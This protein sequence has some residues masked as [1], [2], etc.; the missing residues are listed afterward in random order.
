[1]KLLNHIQNSMAQDT[2]ELRTF[3]QQDTSKNVTNTEKVCKESVP[4]WDRVS[5]SYKH[6]KKK[7]MGST[8]NA[9]ET[10]LQ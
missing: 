2:R 10:D 7:M 5:F 8:G 6:G 3:Q 9:K 4:C 1:V